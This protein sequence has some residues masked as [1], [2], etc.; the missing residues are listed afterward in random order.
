MY[1]NFPLWFTVLT[2]LGFRVTI[3]GRSN[4]EVFEQG[5]ESIPAE[6]ACYP[7]KLAHGHIES[8]LDRGSTRSST[9][10][11]RSSRA[12]SPRPTTTSTAHRRVLPAGA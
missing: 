6:N 5:M 11:S 2:N 4:H 12:R 7:A 8:L 9:R 10:A 3:S 1:E